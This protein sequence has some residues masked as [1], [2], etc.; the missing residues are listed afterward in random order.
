MIQ[1]LEI[2]N[3]KSIKKKYFGLKNL[4]ILLGL[5]GQGKSSFIQSL[6]LLRQSEKLILNGELRLNGGENGLVNIGNSKDAFYQYSKEEYMSFILQFKYTEPN[7]MRF[8]YQIDSDIFEQKTNDL[9]NKYL[10]NNNDKGLFSSELFQYLNAQRVEPKS[11]NITSYSNV[12]N[13][14][15]IGK[16][17]QYTA[18]YIELFANEDVIF[19][20][21]DPS[22]IIYN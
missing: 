17:G 1:S 21:L 5:N 6:L 10:I 2:K 7:E 13:N 18:H 19:D 14:R 15:S 8:K 12:V 16:Y 4:N 20:N 22:Q 9:P 3:F 11:I